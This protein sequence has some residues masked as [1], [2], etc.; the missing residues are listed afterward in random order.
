MILLWILEN[1]VNENMIR[2]RHFN[3]INDD[4][5]GEIYLQSNARFPHSWC[6]VI[7]IGQTNSTTGFGR[8][9]QF[10]MWVV[11]NQRSKFKKKSSIAYI[12]HLKFIMHQNDI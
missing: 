6:E 3:F 5:V 12:R 10:E 1:R 11:C 2:N 8:I 7:H 9:A 4:L